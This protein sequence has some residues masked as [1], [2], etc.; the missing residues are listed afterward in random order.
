MRSEVERHL[1]SVGLARLCVNVQPARGHRSGTSHSHCI[2]AALVAFGR[3]RL[4]G[5]TSCLACD[6]HSFSPKPHMVK[7]LGRA[8]TSR[9]VMRCIWSAGDEPPAYDA[10]KGNAAQQNAWNGEGYINSKSSRM[11]PPE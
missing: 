9:H 7:H 5:L 8:R 4:I 2:S 3:D 11:H 1:A 10:Q 6:S